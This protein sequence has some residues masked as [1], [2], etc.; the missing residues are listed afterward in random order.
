MAPTDNPLKQLI[1]AFP[2]DFASWLLNAQ[3]VEATPLNIELPAGSLSADQ[4]YLVRLEDGRE[5]LLHLEFQGRTSKEPMPWRM[6][7][8]RVRLQRRYGGELISVVLYVGQGAGAGD[9]GVHS[10][11]DSTGEAQLSWRYRVVRLWELE[12]RELLALKR[13]ALL[14]L[15]GQTRI[16]KPEVILPEAIAQVRKVT[17]L[18][19]RSRLV[20][21]L[22]ALLSDE[23]LI[24]MA[25]NILSSLDEELMDLPYFRRMQKEREQG[26]EQGQLE[27]LRRDILN[28]LNARFNPGIAF[29]DRFAR[30]LEAQQGREALERLLIA[31]SQ[32]DSLD[33]LE[34]LLD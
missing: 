33:A 18:T 28:V 17:P 12:A 30:Y 10:V 23:E 14:A 31:I 26:L 22:L 34:P 25:E 9:S 24:A 19:L 8:Y 15:I 29:Q 5:V 3:A 4:L 16:E 2:T 21:A 32:A 13:P 11:R 20:S 27:Q 1:A 7:E 6:L